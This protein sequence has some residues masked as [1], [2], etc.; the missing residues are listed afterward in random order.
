MDN[1]Q[2]NVTISKKVFNRAYLPY[3]D[4]EDRYLVIYGGSGSGKSYFIAERYVYKMLRQKMNLLVV[5]ATGK[6]NRDSTFALIKQIINRW[7][8]SQLFKINE[9]DMRIKCINN[10]N[11]I[12][13]S[14]LDDVEKLKSITFSNGELTDIW[15]EEASEVMEADFNQLDIRLRGKGSKKQ[16]VLS[17]NPIDINHWIKKKLIDT[18]RGTVLRTTY[19]DNEFL[20]EDY[21]ALLESY[22]ETDPYYYAVYCLG[23]WGV[24]G[25]TIF[26]ANKLSIRLR[27]LKE[28]VKTGYFIY[29]YDGLKITDI[30]WVDDIKGYIRVYKDVVEETPYVVGGD[31]AGDGSDYFIGQVINNS[32]GSQ[33]AVLRHQFD[34]D[35]YARQIYCLGMYYNYALLG[36][37]A[38]FSTYPIK[39]LQ[40]LGYENMFF[41]EQEDSISNKHIKKYG[42]KTTSLTR[43]IMLAELVKIVRESTE[44]I[45]DE[46]TINEMITFVR[47]EKGRPEAQQGCHDDLVMALAIAYYCRKQQISVPQKVAKPKSKLPF[48][49]QTEDDIWERNEEEVVI[50]W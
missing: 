27:E 14:G 2:I 40:R 19:K 20:D 42:V 23:E 26:D 45:N 17:F 39:E 47:N 30:E 4:N 8:L 38:N 36:I 15:I 49:L 43:P 34:E 24:Y 7:G 46:E 3:L 21:K 41:R 1:N 12:V 11:E 25:S 16:I 44:C 32:N 31:T 35:V 10:S 5:R 28:P 37:E 6:S 33:V 22:K 48:A 9:S 50:E 18:K 13:F 29:N